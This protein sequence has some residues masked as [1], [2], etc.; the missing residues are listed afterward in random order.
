M[1][2]NISVCAEVSSQTCSRRSIIGGGQIYEIANSLWNLFCKNTTHLTNTPN[3]SEH[4]FVIPFPFGVRCL[5][6]L[7]IQKMLTLQPKV[8]YQIFM[9]TNYIFVD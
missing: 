4:P 9:K 2:L 3:E 5:V 8:T 6:P 1:I 7:R